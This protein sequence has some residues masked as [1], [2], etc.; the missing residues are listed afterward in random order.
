MILIK[1]QVAHYYGLSQCT[2]YIN[3]IYYCTGQSYLPMM[4]RLHEYIDP[5]VV[6][7]HG[8]TIVQ[9]IGERVQSAA[10]HIVEQHIASVSVHRTYIWKQNTN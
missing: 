9:Q 8:G 10:G 2:M 6:L 4:N 7:H 5:L 1:K 3:Y